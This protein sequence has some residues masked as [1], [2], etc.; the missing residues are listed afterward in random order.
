MSTAGGGGPQGHMLSRASSYTN[1]VGGPGGFL[2]NS[3]DDGQYRGGA[4]GKAVR[5][6][7]AYDDRDDKKMLASK[8]QDFVLR[9][10]FKM[11]KPGQYHPPGTAEGRVQLPQ[12][13]HH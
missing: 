10:G 2:E 13:P 5:L 4:G 11:P 9:A 7:T 1:D 12:M 3:V 6:P 8:S